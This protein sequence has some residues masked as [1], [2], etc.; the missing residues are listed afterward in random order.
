[1][2]PYSSIQVTFVLFRALSCRHIEQSFFQ[3]KT[4]N[5]VSL[6]GNTHSNSMK[7]E[8]GRNGLRSQAGLR[9]VPQS[10]Y[11]GAEL[12]ILHLSRLHLCSFGLYPSKSFSLISEQRQGP[13]TQPIMQQNPGLSC[14]PSTI[15]DSCS[16]TG[17]PIKFVYFHTE[18]LS[19]EMGQQQDGQNLLVSSTCKF[20]SLTPMKAIG[21]LR[22]I[23]E[24]QMNGKTKITN[25]KR[26]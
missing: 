20:I 1:M 23:W 10:E 9:E 12:D 25:D 15:K 17:F 2:L 8:R 22:T 14:S 6:M 11:G 21:K 24:K 26:K 18:V 7:Q 4:E 5:D 16:E 13:I 19:P 3:Y